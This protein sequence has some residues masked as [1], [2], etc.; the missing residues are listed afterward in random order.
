V[1][2]RHYLSRFMFLSRAESE[3]FQADNNVIVRDTEL[4]LFLLS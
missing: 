4:M 1:G 3:F 2:L